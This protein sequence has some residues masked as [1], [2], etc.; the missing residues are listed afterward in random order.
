[1]VINLLIW[2]KGNDD[3]RSWQV[4]DAIACW[5]ELPTSVAMASFAPISS[6]LVANNTTDCGTTDR[7]NR[8]AIGQDGA[9]DA[10]D[11]STGHRVLVS[12]CHPV[13]T[14]QADQHGQDHQ[15]TCQ[16]L[17]YFH[18]NLSPNSRR[19]L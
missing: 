11:A 14:T 2:K 1:M 19:R 8:A 3:Q 18:W 5:L 9:R 7:S 10:T 17:F 6:D 16:L 13:A 4:A 15:A 12:S